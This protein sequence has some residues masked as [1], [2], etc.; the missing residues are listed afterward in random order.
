MKVGK[1]PDEGNGANTKRRKRIK[2][3]MIGGEQ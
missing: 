2:F 1:L 3:M